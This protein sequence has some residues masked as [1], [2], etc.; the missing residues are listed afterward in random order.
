[1]TKTEIA[2]AVSNCKDAIGGLKTPRWEGI[3]QLSN[4]IETQTEA[5]LKYTVACMAREAHA[6]HKQD[7]DD[8]SKEVRDRLAEIS[9]WLYKQ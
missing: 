5:E 7:G 2:I 4:G 1:M 9:V 3:R 6:I 8:A